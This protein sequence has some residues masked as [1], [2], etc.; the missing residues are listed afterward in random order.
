MRWVSDLGDVLVLTP[1]VL[2]VFGGLLL[3]RQ[4]VLA[5][6]WLL[7]VLVNSLAVRVLKGA[8]GRERPAGAAELVTSGASFPSGHAAGALLVYGLLLWIVLPLVARRRWRAVLAVAGGVLIGAIVVSRVL[9]RV[10]FVSDVVGG[11]LLAGFTLLLATGLL[12]PWRP[13]DG[14][15]W[16]RPWP[17]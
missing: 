4:R 16:E 6:G 2:A 7:A 1:L 17:R 14:V 3:R 13:G 12:R 15:E 10:H 11:L 9:L 5:L 8:I